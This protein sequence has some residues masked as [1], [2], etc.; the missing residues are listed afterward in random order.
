MVRELTGF[1]KARWKFVARQ[2]GQDLVEYALIVA[3][4]ALAVPWG[5]EHSGRRPQQ[6]IFEGW[7]NA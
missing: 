1:G 5:H 4:V 6:Y 3:F 7:N 2:E